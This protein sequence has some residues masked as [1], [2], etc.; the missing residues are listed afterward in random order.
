MFYLGEYDEE[1][2]KEIKEYLDKAGLKVETRSCLVMEDESTYTIKE[3][4]SALKELKEV[5][6]EQYERYLSALKNVLPQ[7][8][9]ENFEDLFLKSVDPLMMEKKDKILALNENP[10]SFPPEDREA[11]KFGSDE[12]MKNTLS[13]ARARTFAAMVL[14]QNDITIGEDVEAKLDDPIIE[15]TVDPDDYKTIPEKI[16]CEIDFYLDKS[17]LIFVDEFTTPLASDITDEFWDEY[18]LEAQRLKVLGLLIEKLAASPTSR[19]M[20][21]AEFAEECNL[22][23]EDEGSVLN[24]YGDD[25]AEDLA[26]VLEKGGVVKWKGDKLKWKSNN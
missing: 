19:K 6:Y 9:T 24:V 7:A 20:D 14:F 13:I 22:T 26:R 11:L 12:W 17:I 21:F 23:L 18:P 3:K 15:I 8:T 5:D 16:K 1:T 10:E 25:V 4:L 2:A